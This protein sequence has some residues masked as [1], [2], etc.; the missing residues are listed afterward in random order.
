MI[1]VCCRSDTTPRCLQDQRPNIAS[2]EYPREQLRLESRMLG[3]QVEDDVFQ[4]E[5]DSGGD[6]GGREDETD[7]LE[8]E[9]GGDQGLSFM[10][11]RP[12]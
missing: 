7:D 2:D 4:G 10:R 12:I 11:I 9:G 1:R 3:A 6:E 8:F 5:V